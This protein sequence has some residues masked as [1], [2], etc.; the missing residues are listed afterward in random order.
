M[1]YEA[2]KQYPLTEKDYIAIAPHLWPIVTGKP[3]YELG[4]RF[5]KP[6]GDWEFWMENG[7]KVSFSVGQ[8]GIIGS[9]SNEPDLDKPERMSNA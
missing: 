4:R 9:I 5:V 2:G 1:D 7:H 3:D 8:F 6:P